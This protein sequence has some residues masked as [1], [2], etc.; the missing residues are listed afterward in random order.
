MSAMFSSPSMPMP[1]ESKTPVPTPADPAV[2]EARRRELQASRQLRGRSATLF[3]LQNPTGA[4]ATA[5]SAA[6]LFGQ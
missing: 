1:L 4:N 6:T 2:E 3:A 5:G